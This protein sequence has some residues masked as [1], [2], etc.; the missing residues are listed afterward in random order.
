MTVPWSPLE[1]HGL[2][3]SFSNCW[4]HN[5]LPIF[6]LVGAKKCVSVAY[7]CRYLQY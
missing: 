2:E 6:K 3:L 1:K 7:I 5:S 4:S